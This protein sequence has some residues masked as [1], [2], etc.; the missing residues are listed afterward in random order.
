MRLFFVALLLFRAPFLQNAKFPLLSQN[1][2]RPFS[3]VA[4]VKHYTFSERRTKASALDLSANICK[5][6][7]AIY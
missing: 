2:R 4:G 6:P 5:H 3:T 1:Q 7:N